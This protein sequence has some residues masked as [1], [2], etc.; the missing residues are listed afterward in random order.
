M[1]TTTPLINIDIL[2]FVDSKMLFEEYLRENSEKCAW[3]LMLKKML[4]EGLHA[5]ITF[6][7]QGG[8]IKAH[9]S[10]LASSSDVFYAMFSY[11]MK[12]QLTSVVEIID[13]TTQ[14]LNV[15]LILLYL[16]N[17]G[18]EFASHFQFAIRKHF[19]ELLQACEKYQ[20]YKLKPV[21]ITTFQQILSPK[22]C[23]Y[24]LNNLSS[25]IIPHAKGDN[26]WK[27]FDTL[28]STEYDFDYYCYIY[29]VMNYD[30]VFASSATRLEMHQNPKLVQSIGIARSLEKVF[31][32]PKKR[33]LANLNL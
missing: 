2:K 8:S 6:K 23:W 30:E 11:N 32:K 1:E 9:K 22:N 16:A 27:Y 12:E 29:I 15:F 10:V 3:I 20:V 25:K 14:G 28:N 31:L 4:E 24:Y 33:K 18:G 7:S 13:M 21:L 19:D 26:V 17:D 5:D